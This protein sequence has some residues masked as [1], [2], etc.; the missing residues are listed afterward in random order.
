[1]KC[2][3]KD[4]LN[5]FFFIVM[6]GSLYIGGVPSTMAYASADAFYVGR[7]FYIQ[8]RMNELYAYR[9]AFL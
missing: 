6:N 8:W 2:L 1:M 9:Y 7:A 3:N 4:F 5:E